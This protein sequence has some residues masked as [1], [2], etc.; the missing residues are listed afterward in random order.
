MPAM[1]PLAYCVKDLFRLA[2]IQKI[3]VKQES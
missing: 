2:N 1:M 3:Y